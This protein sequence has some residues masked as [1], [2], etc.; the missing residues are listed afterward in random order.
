MLRLLW[1]LYFWVSTAGASTPG[2]LGADTE[3]RKWNCSSSAVLAGNFLCTSLSTW[4]ATFFP[5]WKK[6]DMRL[7]GLVNY[8]S[9][10]VTKSWVGKGALA[11]LPL[12]PWPFGHTHPV[13][14]QRESISGV[15]AGNCFQAHFLSSLQGHVSDLKCQPSFLQFP[16]MLWTLSALPVIFKILSFC[17]STP[18]NLQGNTNM[19]SKDWCSKT[20]T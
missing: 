1:A 9:V 15:G 3:K 16:W 20:G 8:Q 18:S 2:S 17:L 14:S 5:L 10:W 7:G 6:R 13:T 11:C 19:V 12:N 4:G